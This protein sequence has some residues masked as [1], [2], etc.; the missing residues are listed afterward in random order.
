MVET[1]VSFLLR[2]LLA[3]DAITLE[4]GSQMAIACDAGTIGLDTIGTNP[5]EVD[6]GGLAV[7]LFSC[8]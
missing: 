4:R 6:C 7:T 1:P 2:V 3:V 5:L 8:V